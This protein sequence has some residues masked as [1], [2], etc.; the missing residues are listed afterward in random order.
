MLKLNLGCG[1][2]T[3]DGWIN[4]DYALGAWLFKIPGFRAVNKKVRLLNLT[5]S[6]KVFI[7]NLCRKLPWAD[8]SVDVVYSSHTL[9]HLSKEEGLSLLQECYRVLKPNG[10]IRIVVP[11]LKYII[12]LYQQ[13]QVAADDVLNLLHVG[14]SSA[15]DGFWKQR[16]GPFI[17]CPHKCMYDDKSLLRIMSEIGFQVTSK[18]AFESNIEDINIIE[19][20]SRTKESVIV[21]GIKAESPSVLSES[22]N[23][24][25]ALKA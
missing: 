23:V 20:E 4:V 17:R 8:N 11:D 6:D 19:K 10:T 2:R 7:H 25:V 1:D 18:S 5:W 3:P 22:T 9:E 15:K 24:G 21:E 16:F 12:D 14:Y 13:Q